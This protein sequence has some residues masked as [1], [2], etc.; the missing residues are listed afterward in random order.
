VKNRI[1]KRILAYTVE[2]KRKHES[3]TKVKYG[4]TYEISSNLLKRLRSELKTSLVKIS[5]W[6]INVDP[7]EL[8]VSDIQPE[9][10][11]K[12]IGTLPNITYVRVS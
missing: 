3:T 8:H 5:D 1:V 10:H 7:G 9:G 6:R 4:I 12:S 2:A 11:I